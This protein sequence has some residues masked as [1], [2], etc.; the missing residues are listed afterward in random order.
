MT[1][2]NYP[3]GWLS[4]ILDKSRRVRRT[5]A[6]HMTQPASSFTVV[7]GRV[8]FDNGIT[9]R[10]RCPVCAWWREWQVKSCS[11]CG[12]HRDAGTARPRPVDRDG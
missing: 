4:S 6:A 11:A 7:N 1:K 8:V 2:V 12:T 3:W 5:Q 10:W 9:K